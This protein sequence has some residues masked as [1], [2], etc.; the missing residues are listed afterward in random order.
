LAAGWSP[1]FFLLSF[2]TF[3]MPAFARIPQGHG[4]SAMQ[5]I[6]ATI[7]RSLFMPLFFGTVLSSLVLVG[8][9]LLHWG[10]PGASAM[11]AA[12]SIYFV[13]MFLCTI[14]FNVPLNNALAAV[15]SD[16]G[17]ATAVWSRYLKV[18]TAWNHVRTVASTTACAL[19]ITAISAA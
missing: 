2:S 5:S 16:G 1:A 14:F 7:L 13:G 9:V 18:W 15:N 4:I 11:L 8:D 17:E 6:N 19:F 3:I 12:G 10:K